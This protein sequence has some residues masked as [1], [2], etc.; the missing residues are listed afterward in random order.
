HSEIPIWVDPCD[1]LEREE[2]RKL[3]HRVIG[4]MEK[5]NKRDADILRARFIDEGLPEDVCRQF[6]IQPNYLRVLLYRAKK[7]F[8]AILRK[9]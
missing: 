3:V 9:K 6:G 2:I 8:R 7:K 4:E 5:E 1:D